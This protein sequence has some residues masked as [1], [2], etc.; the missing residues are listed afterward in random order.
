MSSFPYTCALITGAS[1]G[2]GRSLAEALSR[3]GV[4]TVLVARSEKKLFDLAGR[5]GP[6]AIAVPL[7][8]TSPVALDQI[9]AHLVKHGLRVDL[10]INN[11][12]FGS[13]GHFH[14][15]SPDRQLEMIELN[16]KAV[17]RWTHHFLPA[18][19]E[20]HHGAIINVSSTASFQ[21]VPFMATYGA[22]KAFVTSFSL[23]LAA[24]V[25]AYGVRVMAACPGRTKT[26]FQLVAGSNVVRIRSRSASPDRVAMVIL[27]A[28]RSGRRLVIEGW[29]NKLSVQLQRLFS[30]RF[31]TWIAYKIFQPKLSS[32]TK[33][34][35]HEYHTT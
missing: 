21:P 22:T 11:A 8:I 28:L 35:P 32:I 5:L 20:R 16:V 25:G 10:L 6:T 12:G 7:D 2:I 23:A 27:R 13:Y 33:G 3:L 15:T 34:V 14:E 26:N 9:D 29:T 19:I 17:V 4:T 30:R 31:V 1:S 18:M 24:E